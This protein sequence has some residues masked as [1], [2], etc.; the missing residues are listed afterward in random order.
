MRKLKMFAH[1]AMKETVK[2]QNPRDEFYTSEGCYIIEVSNSV[3]DPDVSIARA[4]LEPGKTTRWHRLDGTVERYV[5]LAGCG[6][7]EIGAMPPTDVAVGDVVL[8]PPMCRQRIANTGAEDLIFLAICSPR[9]SDQAYEDIEDKQEP[10]QAWKKNMLETRQ[11]APEFS[12]PDQEGHKVSLSDYKN[13]NH[14]VLYFYPKD[15]TPGCTIEA[16]QFTALAA[17]FG[18]LGTVVLGVS[19]D[20]CDSHQAFI[21]KYGLN[22]KLL[23]DTDGDLCD[24]YGV[25]Q[26]K[27]KNGEKK[28]GIVRSTF[29]INKEGL[30][31]DVMYGVSADGHAQEILDKIRKI[32]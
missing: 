21:D 5:I 16:Q 27:E 17:E 10:L 32:D 25:W 19:K 1:G 18:E 11:T 20:S 23:A 14:V 29:I 24:S 12:V 15:D 4:R 30:L 9:Y 22:V 8:I 7:V 28:M 6:R 26:E 3:D 31:E 13:R 2:R